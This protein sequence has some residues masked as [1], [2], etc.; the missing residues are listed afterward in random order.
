M[1]VN[2]WNS[3]SAWTANTLGTS[4]AGNLIL[5]VLIAAAIVSMFKKMFH[6]AVSIIVVAVILAFVLHLL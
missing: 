1:L 2:L 6:V 3:Y 5:A 4:G